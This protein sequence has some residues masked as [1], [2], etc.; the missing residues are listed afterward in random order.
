M[1]GLFKKKKENSN[2]IE[3]KSPLD[4]RSIPLEKVPDDVFA[5]KMMGDGIAVIPENNIVVSPIDGEVAM[6]M[7][8]SKHA[9]AITHESGLQVL[10]HVG[11]DTVSLNGEGFNVLTSL[12]EKVNVGSKLLEFDK[13]LLESKG[14]DTTTMVIVADPCEFNKHKENEGIDVK[15]TLDTILVYNK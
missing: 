1:F 7:E 2:V 13:E 14:I 5:S 10:I 6:I 8:D 15:A 11:I 4:G 3:I 9:I 12:N